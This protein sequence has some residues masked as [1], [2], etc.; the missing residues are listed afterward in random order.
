MGCLEDF[1]E[2]VEPELT[3]LCRMR[4]SE[5][6]I[7]VPDKEQAGR[8]NNFYKDKRDEE[9]QFLFPRNANNLCLRSVF[10]TM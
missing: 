2:K 5:T 4:K 8:K 7:S 1:F 9:C 10:C 6:D 3:V